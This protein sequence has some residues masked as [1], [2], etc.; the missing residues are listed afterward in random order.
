MC[1]S[2]STH[3]DDVLVGEALVRLIVF[4]VFEQHFVHVRAGVL[5]QLVAAGEYDQRNFAVAQHGQLVRLLH[6]AELALVESHLR[7]EMGAH[8]LHLS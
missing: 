4:G 1:L 3:L 5:V 2:R 8:E 7:L 6:D